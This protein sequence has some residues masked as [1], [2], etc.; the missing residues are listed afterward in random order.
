MSG[1]GI[2]LLRGSNRTQSR[3]TGFDGIHVDADAVAAH[4]ASQHYRAYAAK[5]ANLAERMAIP[6]TP[7][8]VA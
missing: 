6:L 8:A 4:R 5:I 2:A 3:P 1:Q 7:V